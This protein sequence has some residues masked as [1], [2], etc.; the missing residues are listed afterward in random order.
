[1]YEYYIYI[2]ASQRR[3][4]LYIGVTNDLIRRV[5]E[6]RND[7]FEGFTKKYKV[8]LLVHYEQ[9]DDVSVAI[10][11]EKRLKKLK[12]DWKIQLIVE[13]NPGWSD[14]YPELVE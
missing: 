13:E 2:L 6:H 9:C 14:L 4:T 1:M 12:R 5:E 7:V 11:R 10:W 3:G 8:H